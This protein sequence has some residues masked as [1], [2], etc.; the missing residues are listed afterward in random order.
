M[1]GRAITIALATCGELPDG[2]ADDRPLVAALQRH[3]ARARWVVWDDPAARWPD[4]DLVLIR[5]TWD[6]TLRHEDFL[7]WASSAPRLVNPAAIVAWSSDKRYLLD[8][9]DAGVPIV[10]TAVAPPGAAATLPGGRFVIKPS[11][12]AGTRGAGRFDGSGEGGAAG[13]AAA[14]AHLAQLHAAGRTAL[15][16]PYIDAIDSRGETGLVFF[17]GQY[18]HAIRKSS[19]L[20]PGAAYRLGAQDA[21]GAAH[22]ERIAPRRATGAEIAAAHRALDAAGAVL[23][24]RT[25]SREAPAY[26]R[27]DLLPG[28]HGPLL[29]ELELVEPSLFLRYGPADAVDRFAASLVERARS[30]AA[31]S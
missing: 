3:G 22:P 24:A 20:P 14:L 4:F 25:G 26:A 7:A 23:S 31:D 16:Q 12:G 8:L 9:A 15:I 10:P 27:V 1:N 13:R 21:G 6:Y 2:D 28:E 19:M 5:S 30:A 17:G 18:S 29:I 11:V